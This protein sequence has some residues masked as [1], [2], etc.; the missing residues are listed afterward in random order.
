M[1][2]S[3][4]HSSGHTAILK[5]CKI[6]LNTTFTPTPVMPSLNENLL[7]RDIFDYDFNRERIFLEIAE[8]EIAAMQKA[9]VDASEDN[10]S[11]DE[12][13]RQSA[14]LSLS[15]NV[16][17]AGQSRVVDIPS[18]NIGTIL[19]IHVDVVTHFHKSLEH[20][21]AWQIILFLLLV[22]LNFEL[23][24]HCLPQL[25]RAPSS[26][27]EVNGARRPLMVVAGTLYHSILSVMTSTR[28]FCC[29]DLFR[30]NNVNLD[31]LTETYNVSFYL[32]YL[33][34]W[35]DYFLVQLDPNN[36]IM[37]YIM[38]KAEGQGTDWH[39]HVT[40]VTVAPEFRRLGL[41]KKL[42]DYL[43]NVSIELYNGYFVDL[44]VRVS[45]SLAIQMYE[46]FGY[47]VY[48]RVLGYYSSA[49]DKED[50]FDMRKA[51]PRDVDKK[52]IIPLPHPITPDQL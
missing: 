40:A 26:T 43:E 27:N 14:R 20:E 2:S 41:A 28:K 12:L 51:L 8:A 38:G 9:A 19:S 37:G 13:A 30:F 3:P 7:Q 4:E 39:G 52:S 50:A 44:F 1:P 6:M 34:K 48:R 5:H 36:T 10:I 17:S 31:V 18:K 33:S 35:P 32:Q 11:D 49:E 29:D 16:S 45:N 42:M 47:S 46:K 24:R 25:Q 23:Q 22:C 21:A 15:S